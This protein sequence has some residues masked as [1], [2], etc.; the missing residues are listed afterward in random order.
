MKTTVRTLENVGGAL[1]DGTADCQGHI[2][3]VVQN[4]SG[5]VETCLSFGPLLDDRLKENLRKKIL[6]P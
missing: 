2:L 1:I 6:K 4:G 3:C 5:V